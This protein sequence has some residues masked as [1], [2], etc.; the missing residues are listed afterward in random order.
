MARDDRRR[1]GEGRIATSQHRRATHWRPWHHGAD[2]ARAW[3]DAALLLELGAERLVADPVLVVVPAEGH[4]R[5]QSAAE[6]R[7]RVAQPEGRRTAP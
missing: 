6:R 3:L 4:H 5:R 7:P 1:R 2:E